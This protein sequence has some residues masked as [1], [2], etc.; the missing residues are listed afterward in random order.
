MKLILKNGMSVLYK[1]V[2]S[3]TGMNI[4]SIVADS[5]EDRFNLRMLLTGGLK[6]DKDGCHPLG[7]NFGSNALNQS[8]DMS[9]YNQPLS[10]VPNGSNV[11]A[12]GGALTT[13]IKKNY[14]L[15]EKL[16]IIDTLTSV[17]QR[18]EPMMYQHTREAETKLLALVQSN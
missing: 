3:L 1:D 14:S 5:K 17:I 16:R 10:L 11:S 12:D 18:N 2:M 13:S 8:S 15:E 7:C 9:N 6:V 4:V